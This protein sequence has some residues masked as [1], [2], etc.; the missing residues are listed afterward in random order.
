[1]EGSWRAHYIARAGDA[2]VRKGRDR[3]GREKPSLTHVRT[4]LTLSRAR[5]E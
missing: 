5:S 4:A 1:M 3:K 2:R